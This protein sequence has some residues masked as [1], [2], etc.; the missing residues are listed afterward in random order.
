MKGEWL[1][2]ENSKPL[3]ETKEKR[4]NE[5]VNAIKEAISTFP[6]GVKVY[7][8]TSSMFIKNFWDVVIEDDDFNVDVIALRRFLPETILRMIALGVGEKIQE[9]EYN[10][11]FSVNSLYSPPSYFPLNAWDRMMRYAIDIELRTQK[12]IKD[13]AS[14]PNVRVTEIN[15][16]D[17]NTTKGAE[18]MFIKLGLAITPET[19]KVAGVPLP[20]QRVFKTPSEVRKYGLCSRTMPL[21]E[22][23]GRT[24]SFLIKSLPGF[25]PT[26]PQMRAPTT[27]LNRPHNIVGT[28]FVTKANAKSESTIYAHIANKL[29][30]AE[31]AL[32]APVG[33]SAMELV[34]PISSEY[35]RV[36][37][38]QNIVMKGGSLSYL[39][40][41]IERFDK[42]VLPTHIVCYDTKEGL[43]DSFKSGALFQQ[44]VLSLEPGEALYV[45]EPNV[46]GKKV[47]HKLAAFALA[48]RLVEF[49]KLNQELNIED[50]PFKYK[51]L[52]EE[53]VRMIDWYPT[54][55]IVPIESTDF[56]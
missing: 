23:K 8:E 18:N 33:T 32:V 56:L 45:A 37:D 7:A 54:Y 5:K 40:A 36:M 38:S 4:K 47:K 31:L 46:E 43:T 42:E 10:T 3:S 12:F 39:N 52:L 19:K 26:L 17:I 30:F 2:L 49:T 14:K 48:N 44:L 50:L 55:N 35:I 22:A 6:R 20:V 13:T 25:I 1:Q 27:Y 29:Q 21:T 9:D 53:G 16:Q 41:L 24:F 11:T 15:L 34:K 28:V 51:Y